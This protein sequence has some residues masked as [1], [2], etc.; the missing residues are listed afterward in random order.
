[1]SVA[2]CSGWKALIGYG[3]VQ[4]DLAI[5]LGGPRWRNVSD[6]HGELASRLSCSPS[7]DHTVS[8]I[9]LSVPYMAEKI[10]SVVGDRARS[11]YR[12]TKH[13]G[14][15]RS[16]ASLVASSSANTFW[17]GVLELPWLL[18]LSVLLG[19]PGRSHRIFRFRHDSQPI[20]L[21]TGSC[22]LATTSRDRHN[23]RSRTQLF[24]RS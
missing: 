16:R 3:N 23:V 1:M 18:T 10:V 9:L 17:L 12:L 5:E 22:L 20:A 11:R 2:V 4:T 19:P 7:F 24:L 15:F 14:R 6:M 13:V 21:S 8:H